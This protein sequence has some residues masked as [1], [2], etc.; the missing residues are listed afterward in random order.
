MGIRIQPHEVEIVEKEPFEHDKLD[1]DKP[2]KILTDLAGTFEGPCVLSL[3]APWGAGKT[4]FLRLWK[5]YLQNKNFPVVLFNAW[6]TDF[7]EDP[8][9]ALSTELTQFLDQCESTSSKK[10]IEKIK[11]M[12]LKVLQPIGL[13]MVSSV[14]NN[15][16]PG[17]GTLIEKG[18]ECL[19][20]AEKRFDSYSEKKASIKEFRKI[21][22]CIATDVSQEREYPLIV[23]IDEL[24]RCRP[25]YA[26][27][28]LEVAKHLFAVDH[29]VFVVA[30]NRSELCHSIKALY[31][32]GFDASGYLGRFFDVNFHLPKTDPEKYIESLFSKTQFK[33]YYSRTH[34]Q[35]AFGMDSVKRLLK[36]YFYSSDVSLRQM[37]QAIHHLGLVYGSLRNDRKSFLLGTTV[38]MILRT[39]DIQLYDRFCDGEITDFDVY[40]KLRAGQDKLYNRESDYHFLLGLIGAHIGILK[41]HDVE[42]STLLR[43][44]KE[45]N[46][47]EKIINSDFSRLLEYEA[48]N[49][50]VILEI[51]DEFS[52]AVERIALLSPDLRLTSD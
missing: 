47:N 11:E 28:L 10:N 3:D 6:E 17:A 44:I 29:V 12:T 25:S 21:L 35:R 50:S 15:V 27:E 31:G 20:S 42:K 40:N 52:H 23:M 30:V 49:R 4:T 32:H 34:D 36:D 7:S 39:I 46:E 14:V 26:V 22:T 51:S 9:L 16:V 43:H 33:D 41:I 38:A 18:V 19:E 24:D 2:I 1:R 8:L 37:S 48:E 5:G 45:E 13:N